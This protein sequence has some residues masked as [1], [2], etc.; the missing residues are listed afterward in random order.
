MN[1]M[2]GD[3]FVGYISPSTT[4]MAPHVHGAIHSHAFSRPSLRWNLETIHSPVLFLIFLAV[5][6]E[7]SVLSTVV[8][9]SG[10]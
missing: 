7:M 1:V 4:G 3:M 5:T 10:I 2:L 6:S 8:T 9:L